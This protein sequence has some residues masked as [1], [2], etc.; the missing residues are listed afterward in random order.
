MLIQ[1]ALSPG[2]PLDL[3]IYIEAF[4]IAIV[5]FVICFVILTIGIMLKKHFKV[6]LMSYHKRKSETLTI[7]II[8]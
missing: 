6:G 5:D 7:P 4:I 8:R 1:V 2:K 3:F